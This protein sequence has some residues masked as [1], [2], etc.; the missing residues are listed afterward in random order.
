MA[1]TGKIYRMET[2]NDI[3]LW[4]DDED[5]HNN[6]GRIANNIYTTVESENLTKYIKIQSNFSEKNYVIKYDSTI[7][8]ETSESGGE[9]ICVRFLTDEKTEIMEIP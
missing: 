3:K 9:N 4:R 5:G 2:T 6:G 1:K 8:I 7:K